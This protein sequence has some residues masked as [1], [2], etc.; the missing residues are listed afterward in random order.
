M[1]FEVEDGRLLGVRGRADHPYT[2]GG[3]CSK[4]R[5][6]EARHYHPDRLLHPL[7]RVGAKGEG[8]FERISWEAAIGEI[9][10]RWKAIIAAHGPQAIAPY[11]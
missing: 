9:T 8:K 10:D 2:R 1:T 11:S 4:L 6:Y 3:L 5:D 7:K